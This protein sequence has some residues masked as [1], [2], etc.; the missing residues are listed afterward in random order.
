MNPTLTLLLP[1]KGNI[2]G[3]SS[4]IAEIYTYFES[5]F[6]NDFEMLVIPNPYVEQKKHEQL[7]PETLR[8]SKNL[9]IITSCLATGK[10]AALKEG[11]AHSQGQFI[12]YMDIDIPFGL[13]IIKPLVDTLKA[14]ADYVSANRRSSQNKIRLAKWQLPMFLLRHTASYFFNWFVRLMLPISSRDTQAGL[15]GMT[16]Q[17]ATQAFHRQT[18]PGFFFDLEHFVISKA[19]NFNHVEL[20]A[21]AL[22]QESSTVHLLRDGLSGLFWTF[23]IFWRLHSKQYQSNRISKPAIDALLHNLPWQEKLFIRL[24][25]RLTP[26]S[27]MEKYLP[28]SGK[29]LDLGCGHGLLS[30]L[31]AETSPERQVI[32]VDHDAKRIEIAG[33][34][35]HLIPNLNFKSDSLQTAFEADCSAIL[36]IDV[37]HYFN[38][39]EQKSLIA[40]SYQ[41][42]KPGGKLLLRELNPNKSAVSMFNQAYEKSVTTLNWTKTS[43]S[44]LHYREELEWVALLKETGFQ[45]QHENCSFPLF[46]DVLFVAEKP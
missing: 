38:S 36:L 15:K 40:K 8:S 26:Y 2:S 24:R 22:H 1:V 23:I 39:E 28:K 30:T 18:C 20:P 35:N 12:L 6:K 13:E 34:I 4:Q 41:N 19:N 42:L 31:V 32:G 10:G 3:F 5:Q 46:S 44:H 33:K 27:A 29:V 7:L 16:R 21:Q 9:K 43:A 11:F 37:M 25:W 45:V 14:G 17:M